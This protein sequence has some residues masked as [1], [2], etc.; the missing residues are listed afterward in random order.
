LPMIFKL[1][2]QLGVPVNVHPRTLASLRSRPES[3]V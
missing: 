2:E 3:V 1:I